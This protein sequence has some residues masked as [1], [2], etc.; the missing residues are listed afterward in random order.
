MKSKN[1]LIIFTRNLEFGKVKT[2]LAKSVGNEKAFE[3]YQFLLKRTKEVTEQIQL[4]KTV[5]YSEKIIEN[6][7]WSSDFLKDLQI[8]DDLGEKM[9]NA[10]KKAFDIG[11]QKVIIIG[12]DLY[13][14]EPYHIH[15]AFNQLS[16]KDVV[17][18]PAK[19]GGYYLLGLKEIHPNLF[20][21]KN[22]GSSTVRRDTMSDLQKVT[23]HLLEELNDVDI[24][25][26]II[27]HSAFTHF[28]TDL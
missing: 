25:D 13:D 14:I 28:F 11:Y 22:W 10:F 18:G 7:I 26:D 20:K 9:E 21:N 17:I 5:F 27:H 16:T 12:S 4:D 23:I 8:G 1:L 24:L 15:E 2:R 6:D 19:D 3:I